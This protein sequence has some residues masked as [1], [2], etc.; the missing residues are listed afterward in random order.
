MTTLAVIITAAVVLGD[1]DDDGDTS[2]L[3]PLDLD[4]NPRFMDDLWTSDTGVPAP[5][6]YTAVVDM[7]AY[8]Y[9]TDCNTNG[10]P[11]EFEVAAG[12]SVDCNTNGIPDE[13]D[14]AEG[15]S[16]D[17]QPDGVPDECQLGDP[18]YRYQVDNGSADYVFGG[19]GENFD[20]VWLNHFTIKQGRETFR[21]G[22]DFLQR[23][24]WRAG[25]GLAVFGEIEAAG[26]DRMPGGQPVQRGL[27]ERSIQRPGELDLHRL[28][29]DAGGV[30]AEAP[31]Q[32]HLAL[33]GT[34]RVAD[35]R[36]GEAR[37]AAER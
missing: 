16:G 1:L 37:H 4:H 14:I 17:C 10:M 15:D 24:A 35:G 22:P 20:L 3:T 2:E 33:P 25:D 31:E 21:W 8:E 19:A 13:C 11:D 29:E 23:Q 30:R 12:T 36:G 28:V 26:E 34:Q 7:G 6:E 32:Q 18:W 27:Q 9:F 5:P